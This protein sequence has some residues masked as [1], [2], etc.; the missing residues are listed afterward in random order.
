MSAFSL[1]G[2]V[3]AGQQVIGNLLK[4]LV[5]PIVVPAT[6]GGFVLIPSGLAALLRTHHAHH[7]KFR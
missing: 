3:S 6:E 4:Q 7:A 2:F 5:A 1:P